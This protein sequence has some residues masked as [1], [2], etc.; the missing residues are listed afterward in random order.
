MALP[1][2]K[3]G[4]FKFLFEFDKSISILSMLVLKSALKYL[5]EDKLFF[6]C[7]AIEKLL[8]LAFTHIPS[9]DLNLSFP[10]ICL[11]CCEAN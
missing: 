1:A 4:S 7:L 9:T 10:E 5:V 8:N 6:G 11:S 2:Q 3:R